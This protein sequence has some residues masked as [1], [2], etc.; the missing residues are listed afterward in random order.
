MRFV[1]KLKMEIVL[2][3]ALREKRLKWSQERW[4]QIVV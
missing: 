3:L 4:S 1:I 2:I